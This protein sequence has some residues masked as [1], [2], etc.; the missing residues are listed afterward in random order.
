MN[1]F[2]KVFNSVGHVFSWLLHIGLPGAENILQEA[3]KVIDTPVA[4]AIAGLIG[5]K[6]VEV[7]AALEVIAG[8]VLQAFQD[9]GSA[10]ASEGLN[11]KFDEKVVADIKLLYELLQSATVG[12]Q[13]KTDQAG[14]AAAN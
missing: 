2:G 7:Q 4:K 9:S 14:S 3:A 5:P 13:K 1:F 11:V 6:A 10:I 8:N 12:P